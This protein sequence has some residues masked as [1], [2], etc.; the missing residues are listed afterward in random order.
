MAY[1]ISEVRHKEF[2]SATAIQSAVAPLGLT[3]S[4]LIGAFQGY[5]CPIA[6]PSGRGYLADM[7]E[8]LKTYLEQALRRDGLR[9]THDQNFLRYSRSLN[10]HADFGLVHE[11]SS[12]VVFFE[13]EFGVNHERDLLKFQIGASEGTLAAAVMVLSIDPRSIDPAFANMPSYESVSRLI[14]ALQPTYP[15][16]LIGL[17][18]SHAS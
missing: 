13:V 4:D 9:P 6:A 11:A 10:D 17:R 2:P 12:R 3:V 8:N 14:E 18:G 7:A 1:C 5:I 15:L 16:L